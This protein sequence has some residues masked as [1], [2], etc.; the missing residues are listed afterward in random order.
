MF[1][2][3]GCG[4]DVALPGSV[5]LLLAA[6]MD[7][8][9]TIIVSGMSGKEGNLGRCTTQCAHVSCLRGQI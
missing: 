2:F 6:T 3:Y 1:A 4:Y 5:K 8:P 7:M 9:G